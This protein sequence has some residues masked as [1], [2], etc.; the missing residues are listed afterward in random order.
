MTKGT[1]EKKRKAMKDLS[2]GSAGIFSI[3]LYAI[4]T[5][6]ALSLSSGMELFKIDG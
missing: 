3:V 1:K 6:I 2:V 5:I 4:G